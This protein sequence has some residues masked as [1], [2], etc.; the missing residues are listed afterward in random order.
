MNNPRLIA[1]LLIFLL[2]AI[3]MVYYTNK[4]LDNL[5]YKQNH[6]RAKAVQSPPRPVS[7]PGNN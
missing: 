2:F 1:P 5:E 4:M 3:A 6:L 7:Q